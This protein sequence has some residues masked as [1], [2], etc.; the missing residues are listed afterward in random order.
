MLKSYIILLYALVPLIGLGQND[1][2]AQTNNKGKWLYYGEEMPD[3]I[4]KQSK[5]EYNGYHTLYRTDGTRFS[6]GEFNDGLKTGV[7]TY[8]FED[9]ETPIRKETYE[10]NILNGTFEEYYRDGT[11]KETGV[12]ANGKLK[13]LISRYYQGSCLKYLADYD[14]FGKEN[15]TVKY[16]YDCDTINEQMIGQLEFEYIAISG[17]PDG[18]AK[19]YFE[20]GEIK[21]V[22]EFEAGEVI[23]STGGE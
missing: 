16:Y 17:I 23:I 4:Q 9:G 2:L 22:I 13:G 20:N 6:E 11:L 19:R 18:K 15:G 1:T 8:Y 14:E 5:E 3:S 7:W 12:Y 10:D 21:E